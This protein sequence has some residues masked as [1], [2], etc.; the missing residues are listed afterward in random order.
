MPTAVRCPKCSWTF[1]VDD[2]AVG[3]VGRCTSC[4]TRFA[5][6]QAADGLPEPGAAVDRY[7]LRERIGEGASGVVYRASHALLGREVAL[8]VL[9]SLAPRRVQRFLRE[10]RILAHLDHPN[11]VRVYDAGQHGSRYYIVSAL[12]RGRTLD[13]LI[14]GGGL[15]P[16]RAAGLVLQ[17]LDALAYA[18]TFPEGRIFHRDV[19]PANVL[20]DDADRLFLTDFGLAGWVDR[21][22]ARETL[23]G[24]VMGTPAYMAPEQA[25]GKVEQVGPASDLYGAGVVLY[26]ALTGRVPFEEPWPVVLYHILHTPPPPPRQ[27]RPDLDPALEAI[28]LKALAKRPEE[29]YRTAGEF[30]DLLRRWQDGVRPRPAAKPQ[31]RAKGPS[32]R[33]GLVFLLGALALVLGGALAAYILWPSTAAQTTAKTTEGEHRPGYLRKLNEGE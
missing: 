9:R 15:E 12:I 24:V 18:H 31:P 29:R 23:D 2:E 4:G 20:V 27:H 26:Q 19:K 14:P 8:K 22:Q 3:R 6:G 33:R 7:T 21:D 11:I 25:E 5:L 32:R 17:L 10:A 28:C 1:T 13:D 16:V 30:A